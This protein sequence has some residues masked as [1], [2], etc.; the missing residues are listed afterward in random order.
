MIRR[1][2]IEL[3]IAFLDAIRRGDRDGASALLEQGV[4]W[5]GIEREQRCSGPDDAVD[6]FLSWRDRETDVDR[7]EL[8]ATEAGAVFAFHLPGPQPDGPLQTD[9]PVYHALTVDSGRI[10]RIEDHLSL[11]EAIG[12]LRRA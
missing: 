1:E 2:H 8:V 4:V 5:R 10:S 11:G 7:L 3:V 9:A 6:G 12:S